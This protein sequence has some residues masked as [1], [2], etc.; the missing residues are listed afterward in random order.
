MLESL[1]DKVADLQTCN[2]RS[3]TQVFFCEYCIF[4]RVE[5]ATSSKRDSNTGVF[6]LVLH[7]F[8]NTY[9]EEGLR[10]AASARQ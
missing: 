8:K 1:F 5:P 4:L 2:F 10:T 6:L 7:F 9:F 3:P